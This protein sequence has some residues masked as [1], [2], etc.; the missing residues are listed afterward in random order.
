[1]EDRCPHCQ[2]NAH[3]HKV[4]CPFSHL[5]PKTFKDLDYAETKAT[6]AFRKSTIRFLVAN[7]IGKGALVFVGTWNADTTGL[8]IVNEILWERVTLESY[9][10]ETAPISLYPLAG[11]SRYAT[12][13]KLPRCT[14]RGEGFSISGPYS[15]GGINNYG[16]FRVV[17]PIAAERV[18]QQMPKDVEQIPVRSSY[19]V[20]MKSTGSMAVHSALSIR[21]PLYNWTAHAFSESIGTDTPTLPENIRDGVKKWVGWAN[22]PDLLDK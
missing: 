4:A 9:L 20:S 2:S 3:H 13:A 5:P 11:S 14:T 16:M 1:M 12:H 10:H 21:R 18:I 22:V 8:Y 15:H 19:S 7:G 6:Y 17:S